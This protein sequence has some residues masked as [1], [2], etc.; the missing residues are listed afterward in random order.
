MGIM[1]ERTS[2]M[3]E[4]SDTASLNRTCSSASFRIILGSPTVERVIRFG[5]MPRPSSEVIISMA[6]STFL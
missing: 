1:D 6:L 4:C 5:D 2:S 3:A